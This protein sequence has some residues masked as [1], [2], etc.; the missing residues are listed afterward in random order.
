MAKIACRWPGGTTLAVFR[1]GAEPITVKL[2]GPPG[3]PSLFPQENRVRPSLKVAALAHKR[4]VDTVKR[5]QDS[6]GEEFIH[7]Q[8]YGVTEVPGSFWNAWLE[9]NR[10]FDIVKQRMVFA[11]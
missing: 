10:E 9:A 11:L 4:V 3:E 1:P 6:A 7:L 5:M 2:N 8:D